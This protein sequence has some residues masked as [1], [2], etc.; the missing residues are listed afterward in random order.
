MNELSL[1]FNEII[2]P[3]EMNTIAFEYENCTTRL[4]NNIDYIVRTFVDMG[5]D[6]YSNCHNK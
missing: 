6:L 1:K 4:K 3:D 2:K 5:V